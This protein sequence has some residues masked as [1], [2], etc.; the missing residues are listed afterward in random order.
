MEANV[1]YIRIT[2]ENANTLRDIVEQARTLNPLD[3]VLAYAC[4]YTK[5]IQEL[6]VYVSDT[7][8]SSLMKSEKL[9]AV[10]LMNKSRKGIVAKTST[11]SNSNT[12][13]QVDVRQTQTT[14][15]PLMPSINENCSP[16]A[17]RSKLRSEMKNNGILQSLSSNQKYQKV[18]AHSRNAKPM[19]DRA[20]AKAIKSIKMKEWK[21]TV[22]LRKPVKS[23]IISNIKPSSASQWRPK[24]TN[25]V[26]SSSAPKIIESMTANY[27]EPNNHMGSNVSISLC[28]LSVQ[29]RSYKLYLDNTSGPVPQRKE[30]CTLQCTL[31]SKEEKS[32]C[33]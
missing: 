9:V 16:N 22:H 12:Q 14:N 19:N 27:L 26:S 15:K 4:M 23:T 29:C 24:E 32:S 28:S 8:P 11:T 13:I 31:S 7:C 2:K 17:S 5:Q 30:R 1:D 18:E 33:F 20:R 3:N 25:H 21:P 6:L 10:I